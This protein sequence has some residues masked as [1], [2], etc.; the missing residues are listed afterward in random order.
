MRVSSSF[1]LDLWQIPK[2]KV[3]LSALVQLQTF[4]KTS[5][6]PGFNWYGFS[7]PLRISLIILF[8]AGMSGFKAFAQEPVVTARFSNPTYV[9]A[10]QTYS[11]DAE[12]QCNTINQELFGMNVRFFYDDDV[13]EFLS[14]GGFASGYSA[15]CPDPPIISTG[16][17]STGMAL[18]G[19]SGPQEYINGAVQKVSSSPTIYL[20]TTGWTKLFSINFHVDDPEALD[21]ESF[22]PS[23]VWDLNEDASGGINPAGGIV[24]T[25]VVT[26]PNVTTSA[27]ENCFQFNWQYDGIPGLPHGYPV[28]N[29]CISTI[30]PPQTPVYNNLQNIIVSSG[31][32]VCEDATQTI[33]VAGDETYY[34]VQSGADVTL[35]AG[36]DIYMLPGTLIGSGANLLATITTNGNYCSY[37][38]NAIVSNPPQNEETVTFAPL[39]GQSFKIYPNP[40]TGHFT[41]L[42]DKPVEDQSCFFQVVGMMGKQIISE[43]LMDS[44][45][46]EFDLT[47]Q[48][49]GIY[50]V[51]IIRGEKVDSGKIIKQ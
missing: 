29:I 43:K 3:H 41:L 4:L 20:S 47:G 25:L 36:Q 5:K 12:F 50:M 14:F 37:Y 17:P 7:V 32:I 26:Y 15:V 24:I 22:C 48:N 44:D 16:T 30:E 21:I 33:I 6:K 23:A 13:L 28:N 10:T 38:Q 11:L 39:E 42:L 49:P 46:F 9:Y 27:I 2:M 40:T 45:H 35:V 31:E 8:L 1:T 18:F 51:R 34:T 19:F